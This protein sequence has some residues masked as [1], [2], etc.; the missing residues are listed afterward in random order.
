M[1][2][3]GVRPRGPWIRG[4]PLY[5]LEIALSHREPDTN[6]PAKDAL[7]TFLFVVIPFGA[8]VVAG[9]YFIGGVGGAA[10]EGEAAHAVEAAPAAEAAPAPAAEAAPAPAAEAA[11]VPAAEAAPAPAPAP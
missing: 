9:L 5:D 1:R 8:A 11:P 6:S 3:L 2:R 7:T 10:H 4:R